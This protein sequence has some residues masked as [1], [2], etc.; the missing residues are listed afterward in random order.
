MFKTFE[1]HRIARSVQYGMLSKP[2]LLSTRPVHHPVPNHVVLTARH[3]GMMT[4]SP[5]PLLLTTH[6]RSMLTRTASIQW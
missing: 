6:V 1:L 2:P 3:A 5:L 4:P